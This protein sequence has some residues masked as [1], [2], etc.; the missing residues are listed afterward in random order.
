MSGN[1]Y[2]VWK[3]EKCGKGAYVT[4]TRMEKIWCRRRIS[5]LCGNRWSTIEIP[6]ETAVKWEKAF[7]L[8]SIGA[9]KL[10]ILVVKRS[11]DTSV[12]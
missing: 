8:F 1:R 9:T 11:Q 6:Y 4:E 7:K 2:L 10:G 12:Y 3:C 5:C